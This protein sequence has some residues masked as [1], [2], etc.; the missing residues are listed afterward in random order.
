M[1]TEQQTFEGIFTQ[2]I[3]LASGMVQTTNGDKPIFVIEWHTVKA[4]GTQMPPQ[5][6]VQRFRFF[7]AAADHENLLWIELLQQIHEPQH[8]RIFRQI[9][10]TLQ[11]RLSSIFRKL[12]GNP[13][14]PMLG[15][16]TGVQLRQPRRAFWKTFH[17]RASVP[18]QHAARAMQIQQI[19]EQRIPRFRFTG[20]H[21]SESRF[22]FIFVREQT[23]NQRSLFRR[24]FFPG[25]QSFGKGRNRSVIL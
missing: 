17:A 9:D 10:G 23:A 13:I 12:C 8:A 3:R 14:Q 4:D 24:K 15:F 18:K 21:R 16:R 2:D 11:R 19:F 22:Q 25:Q 1:A 5:S 7:D 6:F 20:L